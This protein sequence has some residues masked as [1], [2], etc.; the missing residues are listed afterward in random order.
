MVIVFIVCL[1]FGGKCK[2]E[3]RSKSIF[4]FLGIDGVNWGIN[5]MIDVGDR[6][7]NIYL[8]VRFNELI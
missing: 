1:G 8:I 5:E 3:W 7:L 2:E 6:C 4:F